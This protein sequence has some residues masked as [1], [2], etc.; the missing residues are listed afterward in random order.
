[1]VIFFDD[2]PGKLFTGIEHIRT[3]ICIGK[4]GEKESIPATTT[5]NKFHS[6]FRQYLFENIDYSNFDNSVK[7]SCI[8]K[9]NN[10]LEYS[11]TKKLW[12]NKN[13]L[14]YYT[15][16]NLQ[17]ITFFMVMDMDISV[18]IELSIIL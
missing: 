1:M 3:A 2:R 9:I 10:K 18:N 8:L 11:I 5:Y 4:I 13:R 12:S 6:E 17:I 14:G 15:Q 16:K 7:N